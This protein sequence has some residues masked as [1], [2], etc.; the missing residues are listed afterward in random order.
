MRVGVERLTHV[1]V[2]EPSRHNLD[3]GVQLEEQSRDGVRAVR[4]D[5]PNT[6]RRDRLPEETPDQ[7]PQGSPV[8]VANTSP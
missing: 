6:R 2:P 5:A 7:R 4:R 1:G 3:G 8:S